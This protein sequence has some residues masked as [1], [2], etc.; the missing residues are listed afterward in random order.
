MQLGTGAQGPQG[1]PGDPGSVWTSGAGAPSGGVDNDFY[2]RTSNEDVYQKI[3]NVWTVVTNI[4]GAA[5]TNGTDGLSVLSDSGAPGPGDGVDGDFYINTANHDIYGPKTSGTW[6]SPTSLVGPQGPAGPSHNLLHFGGPL[7]STAGGGSKFLCT[8]YHPPNNVG[9][10]ATEQK[11]HATRAGTIDKF[12]INVLTNALG[13]GDITFTVY[14]NGVTTLMTT[15]A[16]ADGVT[17]IQI[18]TANSFAVSDGDV[19]S[20]E[21]LSAAGVTLVDC[22]VAAYLQV[23]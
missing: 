14:L 18:V 4:K 16:I 11:Y 23:S 6:G 12:L 13:G 17:G 20:I 21:A 8:G 10:L 2:L 1:I 7:S 19:L 5:G 22:S 15:G 9:L 3:A